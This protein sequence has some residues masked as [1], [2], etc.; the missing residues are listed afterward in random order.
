MRAER[1]SALNLF[2]FL[3]FIEFET[4][5]GTAIK[6]DTVLY[7]TVSYDLLSRFS[8]GKSKAFSLFPFSFDVVR[9]S[10]RLL[11]NLKTFL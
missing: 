10:S 9:P 4:F 8:E 2:S 6:F 3:F 7:S 1:K 11:L 5:V